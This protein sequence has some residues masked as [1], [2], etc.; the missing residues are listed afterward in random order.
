M[1][2]LRQWTSLEIGL[3]SFRISF[4]NYHVLNLRWEAFALWLGQ[5]MAW[6]RSSIL[7][8]FRFT[9]HITWYPSLTVKI[10]LIHNPI[11]PDLSGSI[12]W[13]MSNISENIRKLERKQKLALFPLRLHRWNMRIQIDG[14][15]L[16][17]RRR[18]RI[19]KHPKN[20]DYLVNWRTKPSGPKKNERRR[21]GGL[22]WHVWTRLLSPAIF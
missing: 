12:L 9:L 7:C 15:L 4:R 8:V 20:V 18:L 16:M 14:T 3:Y 5:G 11:H 13:M 21:K 17:E 6:I 1:A 10:R 22:Q 19:L 2:Q